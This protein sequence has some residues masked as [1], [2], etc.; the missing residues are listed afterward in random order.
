MEKSLKYELKAML[1]DLSNY[2][3]GE[4]F[5]GDGALLGLIRENDLLEFDNDIDI[6]L[7]PDAKLKLPKGGPY[8]IQKYY[9][10]IKFYLKKNK[11]KKRNTW[12]EYLSYKRTCPQQIG[13]NRPQ[14]TS[15]CS[16]TY[17]EEKII[18]QFTDPY[19][20]IFYLKWD[21]EKYTIGENWPNIYY[22]EEEVLLLDTNSDLG[23]DVP[24]PNNAHNILKRQYGDDYMTPNP[25]FQY[26]LGS[27]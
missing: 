13:L 22:T 25:D 18:P 20:D 4:W 23:F 16:K 3:D 24:I 15:R 21:G 12:L 11:P 1:K 10:D 2:I 7:L 8:E 19:I 14:L 17:K 9:M 6:F 26:H 27:K 5:V